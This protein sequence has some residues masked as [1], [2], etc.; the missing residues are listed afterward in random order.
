VFP[1][2]EDDLRVA[3]EVLPSWMGVRFREPEKELRDA[4]DLTRGAASVQ[5]VFT[6]SPAEQAGLQAGDV[7]LGPPGAHFEDP[8]QVRQWTMLAT[9]DKPASLD[10]LRG[11]ARIELTLVPRPYPVK[12]PELPGPIRAMSAAPPWGPLQLRAYRG[13]LPSDLR[14]S[15]H[16]LYFWATWCGPCKAALPELVAFERERKVPVIAITDESAETLDAFFGTFDKPFPSLV[17]TDAAR[18]AFL[19]YGVSGTPTFVLVDGEGIVSSY[20]VGYVAAK[21]LGVPGW[22]WSGRTEA[23]QGGSR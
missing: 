14:G 8:G 15:G 18:K 5:A 3:R 1:T 2:L 21:G 4:R 9:V 22:T 20:S 12:W 11:E 16:L 19:A 23:L 7:I 6:G 17:A 13:T 10:V